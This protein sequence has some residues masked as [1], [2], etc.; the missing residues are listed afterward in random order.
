MFAL[1]GRSLPLVAGPMP[2]PLR[3]WMLGIIITGDTAL[4]QAECRHVVSFVNYSLPYQPTHTSLIA[5]LPH[6]P[7]LADGPNLA[8]RVAAGVVTDECRA[9]LRPEGLAPGG[10]M[11]AEHQSGTPE[12]CNGWSGMG[13]PAIQYRRNRPSNRKHI[14]LYR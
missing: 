6:L 1:G 4:R 14:G 13:T 10:L 12:A 3:W 5:R 7:N 11:A 9:G 8:G 2:G